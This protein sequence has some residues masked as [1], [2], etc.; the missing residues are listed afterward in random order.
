VQSS[1]R[2]QFLLQEAV[3]SLA[4]H[5]D[6]M[7][8]SFTM[9]TVLLIR[10]QVQFPGQC[11]STVHYKFR[12]T[13]LIIKSPVQFPEGHSC[14]PDNKFSSQKDSCSSSHVFSS[15]Q[16]SAAYSATSSFHMTVLLIRLPFH[17][18]KGQCCSSGRQFCSQK[19]SAAHPVASSAPRRTVL[20]IRS[21]LQLPEG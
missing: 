16:D 9:R 4:L 19:D 8:I 3:E 21:P 14:S 2:K 5:G 6:M 18:P 7:T 13:V 15:Q 20:L 12:R 11:S 1:D 10:S 17:S